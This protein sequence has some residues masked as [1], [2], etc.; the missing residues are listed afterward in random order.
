MSGQL[1]VTRGRRFGRGYCLQESQN[2]TRERAACRD[3]LTC[4][5]YMTACAR[6]AVADLADSVDATAD[7]S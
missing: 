6:F 5:P 7:E 4:L 2:E 1:E 3:F